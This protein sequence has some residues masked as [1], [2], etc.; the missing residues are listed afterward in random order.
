MIRTFV[1]IELPPDIKAGIAGL[2][3]SLKKVGRG[4]RWSRP[5]GIHLTLKF[6]G[7]VEEDKIENIG[8]RV[9]VACE[10][11]A[12]FHI[13]LA[14]AGAFPNFRR[15]RVFWLGIHEESG[16]LGRLQKE[17]DK[18]L[19]ETGFQKEARA[20]S[21]HLTIGRVKSGDDLSALCEALQNVHIEPMPLQANQV[22]VMQSR[23]RPSGALYTPLKVIN[24]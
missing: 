10:G 19:R 13:E 22:V 8:E 5:E 7:D 9:A 6:L 21:P 15:P 12:P 1:C 3:E 11:I 17:I 2:Q 16:F 4:V 14:Q 18:Q 24:L 20:F 23:L